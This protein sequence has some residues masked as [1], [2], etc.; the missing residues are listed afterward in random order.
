LVP[1]LFATSVFSYIYYRLKEHHASET[2][3][4]VIF[5]HLPFSLYHAWIFVLF[6]INIFAVISPIHEDGPS[7]FQVILAVAGLIF[8]GSTVIGYIEYKKGD[9]AGALVLAW[10]LFGVYAQQEDV[11]IHWTSLVLGVAVSAYT[12]KPVVL[13]FF[14]RQSGESAPLLG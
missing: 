10:F 6:V 8:V 5:L 7:T 13:G 3:L 12:L 9:V 14:G 11:V 2:V 1:L 4:E